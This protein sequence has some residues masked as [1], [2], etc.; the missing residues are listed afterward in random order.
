MSHPDLTRSEDAV[1]SPTPWRTD[2]AN[3]DRAC[4][5]IAG[6]PR[7]TASISKKEAAFLG[8]LLERHHKLGWHTLTV[9]NI[10]VIDPSRTESHP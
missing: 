8:R 4:V 1:S 5:A 2:L 6:T 3:A 7:I 10:F 9:T